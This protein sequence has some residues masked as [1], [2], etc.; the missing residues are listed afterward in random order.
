MCSCLHVGL[1][2]GVPLVTR[3]PECTK[4]GGT[5]SRVHQMLWHASPSH[6]HAVAR[7]PDSTKGDGRPLKVK[8]VWWR[9]FHSPAYLVARIPESSKGGGTPCRQGPPMLCHAFQTPPK[10]V[11]RRPDSTKVV[12]WHSR[13]V[14]VWLAWNSG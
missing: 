12:A 9:T 3:I 2:L 11:A 4:G 14:G 10:V 5:H 13:W 7:I 1:H 6:L 8:Q